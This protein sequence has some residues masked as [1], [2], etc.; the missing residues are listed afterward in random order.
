MNLTD[1]HK[2][3]I[4]VALVASGVLLTAQGCD[5]RQFVPVNVPKDVMEAVDL[6]EGR[7]TLDQAEIVWEDWEQYVTS[8]TKRFENA[9]D[10][11]NNRYAVLHQI[12]S[13]GLE[14]VGTASGGIPYGGLMFGAL[15][16]ITGLLLPTPKVLSAKKKEEKE[17]E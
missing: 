15:T 12:F 14:G 11:A 1:T 13:I 17:K 7:L 16:G 3:Y 5:L 9:V 8:N 2:T 6:P 4:M 10:D